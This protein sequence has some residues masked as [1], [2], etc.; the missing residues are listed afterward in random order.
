MPYGR[1]SLALLPDLVVEGVGQGGGEVGRVDGEGAVGVR[2]AVHRLPLL[3]P[4]HPWQVCLF[5]VLLSRG[6]QLAG[7]MYRL[8]EALMGGPFGIICRM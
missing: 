1:A 7:T 4:L 5:L 8:G 2:R 6:R 3:A